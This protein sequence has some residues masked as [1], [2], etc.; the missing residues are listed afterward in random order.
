M[1]S[2][3]RKL[4]LL[5]E[6]TD[7]LAQAIELSTL[8]HKAALEGATHEE[9]KPEND[10]DTRGLEQSYLARGQAL[11]I[12]E[13]TTELSALRSLQPKA[14]APDAPVDL[15]ALVTLEDSDGRET[16]YFLLPH[17]GG[18]SLD[19]GRVQV[20]TPTAPLARAVLGRQEGDETTLKLGGKVRDYAILRVE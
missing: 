20:V 14:F 13:Q 19:E 9:A 10:K 11:R 2:L 15:G 3:S 6:L 4:A 7:R 16:T 12:A 5:R 18:H 17:G 1:T 8:S